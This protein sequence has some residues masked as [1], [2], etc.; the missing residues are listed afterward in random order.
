M[1]KTDELQDKTSFNNGD[2]M[3][4]FMGG[5]ANTSLERRP[6]YMFGLFEQAA[7][8]KVVNIYTRDGRIFKVDFDQN[9]K[10]ADSLERYI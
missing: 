8:S 5:S 1:T 7:Y 2:V 4:N 9:D 10:A 6:T 3:I